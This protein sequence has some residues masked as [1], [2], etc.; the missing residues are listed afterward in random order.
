M[1]RICVVSTCEPFSSE[2]NL[3]IRF[4]IMYVLLEYC[5]LDYAILNNVMQTI[6]WNTYIKKN[7]ECIPWPT[8]EFR[9]CATSFLQLDFKLYINEKCYIYIYIYE[10]MQ[11]YF[12][13]SYMFFL[14]IYR[15]DDFALYF[16]MKGYVLNSTQIKF[17]LNI[18]K[19]KNIHKLLKNFIWVTQNMYD[20][21]LF[22][23]IQW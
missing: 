14:N 5:C 2:H 21:L 19:E 11:F 8:L 3:E 1:E 15:Y 7:C 17:E 12:L 23:F 13:F 20:I 10:S 4:C 16:N 22:S 9:Y 18:K 6:F